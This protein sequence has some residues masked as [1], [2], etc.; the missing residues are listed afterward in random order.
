MTPKHRIFAIASV[1]P[2]IHAGLMLLSLIL[3]A[4]GFNPRSLSDIVT[5][6]GLGVAFRAR[7]LWAAY[8]L[9][10]YSVLAAIFHVS[11]GMA[12]G[13]SILRGILLP[14]LYL[15]AARQL[16]RAEHTAPPIKALA[17]RRLAVFALQLVAGIV[18]TAF[19]FGF[20]YL[21]IVSLLGVEFLP[22]TRGSGFEFVLEMAWALVVFTRV[23]RQTGPW[24]FESVMLVAL[25]AWPLGLVEVS[26][27]MINAIGWMVGIV[28][29]LAPAIGGWLV[30]MIIS[31]RLDDVPHGAGE[32]MAADS[33]VPA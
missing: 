10:G 4:Q 15:A 25:L 30:A 3:G 16:L 33:K 2:F 29:F 22:V 32:P 5:L 26:L 31:R 28:H 14:L 21:P 24:A 17:W 19:F 8:A 7:H 13:V 6:V 20:G 12:P 27:G 23:A 1:I 11:I 18:V 9:A